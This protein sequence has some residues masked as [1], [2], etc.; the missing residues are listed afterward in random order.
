MYLHYI[1]AS[2]SLFLIA[3]TQN[4]SHVYGY[5]SQPNPVQGYGEGAIGGLMPTCLIILC[6]AIIRVLQIYRQQRNPGTG[7][8]EQSAAE[9][10]AIPT[11]ASTLT[12][13][14]DTR[15]GNIERSR[16]EENN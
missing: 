3:R 5:F 16:V 15:E 4:V 8:R 12:E 11:T 13:K 10:V 7:E 2:L 6:G 14:A 9:P 1:V